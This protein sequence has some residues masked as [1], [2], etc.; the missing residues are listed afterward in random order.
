MVDQAQ[1]AIAA[2]RIRAGGVV[3][4][5]TE[6]V[7]GL[8]ANALDPAAIDLIYE[9]KDRPRTSPLIVHVDSVHMAQQLCAAWPGTAETLARAFWP[10]PLTLVLP[11]SPRISDGLTAGLPTVGLRM[12]SHPVALALILASGV[13]IAAPSANRF[14]GL[15][16]T[17]AG[18][19]SNSLGSRVDLI[20]DAG[21]SAVGIE[22]TVLSLAGEMPVL[23][24]PG[25]ISREQIEALIGPVQ[26]VNEAELAHASPGLH[27][28][29]YSPRTPFYL[30][31]SGD[32]VPAAGRGLLFS[33]GGQIDGVDTRQM[34]GSS[35]AY[36][37]SLYD[38]LHECDQEGWDWLAAEDPPANGEWAGVRD[39]L[40]R[41]SIR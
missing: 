17:R 10:G 21:P 9:I 20:L 39:R 16:P 8:G 35:L 5:P 7:Y 36:A 30:W 32:L 15:S 14:T 22:S 3:A 19:V 27:P 13:P 34:P 24:R 11:K 29:H 33:L 37:A 25:T 40:K 41:A 1:I 28:K 2:E 4:F 38:V 18:H 23:L 12:P 6:T 31:R 26:E